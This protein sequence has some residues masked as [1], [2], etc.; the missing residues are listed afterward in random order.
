MNKSLKYEVINVAAEVEYLKYSR[1]L[2]LIFSFFLEREKERETAREIERGWE[3]RG[4][5][6]RK[7]LKQ[8]PGPAWSM[9]RALIHL[10]TLRS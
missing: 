6:A 7:N 9:M 1:S 2:Q 4:G 3:S 8:A 10:T 5:G